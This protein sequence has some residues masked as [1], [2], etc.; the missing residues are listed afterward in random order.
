MKTEHQP[1]DPILVVDDDKGILR[2]VKGLLRVSGLTEVITCFD[3]RQVMDLMRRHDVSVVLLDAY[4]PRLSGWGVLA[5]LK[6]YFPH[7]PVIMITGSTDDRIREKGLS[8]GAFDVLAK[9]LE[10]GPLFNAVQ[11]ALGDRS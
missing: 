1:Q 8:A 7:V 3:G 2:G 9:P 10:A 5:D 4:M 6:E 11:R